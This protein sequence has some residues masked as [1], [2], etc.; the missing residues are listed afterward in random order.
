MSSDLLKA[1]NKLLAAFGRV[2][3]LMGGASAEREVSLKSGQA[4]YSALSDAGV[5]AVAVD[6]GDNMVTQLAH[7]QVDR[8]F[9]VLHGRGGEDGHVQALLN[10]LQLPFTGSDVLGSALTMDKLATKRLLLGSDIPTPEYV[11]MHSVDDCAR[12]IGQLGLPLFVKP[13][14]EGSSIGMSR[15]TDA[16]DL[17]EAYLKASQF[18]AVFAEKY[19]DGGEYTAGF[20]AH[21]VL[22]LIRL[23]TPR[24]FYDYQAKYVADDTRYHCPCGLDESATAAINQLVLDTIRVT[25]VRHWGRVDLMVDQQGQ[26]WVIEVNTVPGMTDHSL[27]PMAAKQA[28]MDF[29]QLCL[30]ILSLTL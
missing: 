24:T 11:E 27:V 6:V 8:V 13:V 5:D 14:L 16:A 4:V 25:A 28:G 30:K 23:E 20:L 17:A 26:P 29:Q 7:L 19:I 21:S 9:N 1:D 3:V 10:L 15:V 18:G 2:A 12:V 22:P